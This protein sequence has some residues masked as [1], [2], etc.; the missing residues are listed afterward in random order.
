MFLKNIN[1]F[2]K[3]EVYTLEIYLLTVI[4]SSTRLFIQ[5]DV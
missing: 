2:R 4:C 3:L 1:L 5:T